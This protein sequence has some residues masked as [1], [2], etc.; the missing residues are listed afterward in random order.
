MAALPIIEL[1]ERYLLKELYMGMSSL[2]SL[3]VHCLSGTIE[4]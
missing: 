2:L 1:K 3:P 4:Y